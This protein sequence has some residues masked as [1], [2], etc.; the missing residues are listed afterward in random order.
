MYQYVFV[1]LYPILCDCEIE[2]GI[3]SETQE[4]IFIVM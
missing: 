2:D 3:R 1:L 4:N